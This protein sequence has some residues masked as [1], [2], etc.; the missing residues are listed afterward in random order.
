MNP[1]ETVDVICPY[2]SEAFS[3]TIDCS[4][5]DQEYTEDCSVCCAP[6]A[7]RVII[8]STLEVLVERESN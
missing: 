3:L 1:L 5:G 7:I 2:C 6:V 8:G 4:G